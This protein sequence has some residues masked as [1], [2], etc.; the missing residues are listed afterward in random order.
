MTEN[1]LDWSE[2][3]SPYL[4]HIAEKY[5]INGSADPGRIVHLLNNGSIPYRCIYSNGR[6]VAY[7]I[8]A[9]SNVS[10]R[11]IIVNIGF[12]SA[13]NYNQERFKKLLTWSMNFASSSGSKI[14]MDDPFNVP[15]KDST[16]ILAQM[17]FERVERVRLEAPLA[18]FS[19]EVENSRFKFSKLSF[20]EAKNLSEYEYASFLNG[21]DHFLFPEDKAERLRF[22]VNSLS[23]TDSGSLVESASFLAT[24][25]GELSGAVISLGLTGENGKKTA[26]IRSLFVLPPYRKMGL[27]RSLLL[28]AMKDLANGG[29]EKVWLQ[30]NVKNHVAISLYRKYG[31]IQSQYPHEIFYLHA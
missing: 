28:M 16:D 8:A 27:G 1:D 21:P 10:S 20:E 17:G 12:P 31:F 30:V 25:N 6:V 13:E 19:F 5:G 11:R 9:Y 14:Y 24:L 4:S 22:F 2:I 23:S 18:P 15:P 3:L 7:S 29:Y 26:T